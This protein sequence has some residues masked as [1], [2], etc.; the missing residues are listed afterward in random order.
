MDNY[1][2]IDQKLH[3]LSQV[4]TKFNKNYMPPKDDDSHTNIAY[5][6]IGNRLTSRWLEREEGKLMLTLD[7]DTLE[8]SWINNSQEAVSVISALGKTIDAIEAKVEASL[9]SVGLNPKGF[10]SPLHFEIPEYSFAQ[11]PIKKL[12][13]SGL[14]QWKYYR[15][16][17]NQSCALLMDYLQ[18]QGEIRIWPHHFDT[19]IFVTAHD[20]I[21]IGYGLAMEDSKAGAPY[22]YMAGYLNE[23]SLDF[24]S[25]PQL[26]AGRWETAE[27][28]KGALLPLTEL[29]GQ[30]G[31][32]EKL[33]GFVKAAVDWFVK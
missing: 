14:E 18:V 10:R 9:S 31:A 28:F 24:A 23:G 8:F 3:L 22:F 15:Q 2:A 33:A 13:H 4:L 12:D 26:S 7:L 17:A 21:G 1:N 20:K 6:A 5:D 32:E 25:V 11:D 29:E 27:G 19:G 30:K 16:M